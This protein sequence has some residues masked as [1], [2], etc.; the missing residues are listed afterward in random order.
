MATIYIDADFDTIH[1][2]ALMR[3]VEARGEGNA[4][5]RR[6]IRLLENAFGLNPASRARLRWQIGDATETKPPP[7]SAARAFAR[8][9]PNDRPARRHPS[10]APRPGGPRAAG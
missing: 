1:R 6:E 8:S 4:T 7:T 2:L 9:N 10:R 5:L 3:D